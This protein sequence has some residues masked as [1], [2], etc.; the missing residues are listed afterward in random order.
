MN[1]E[2]EKISGW[3]RANKLSINSSKSK[4][5][6][7]YRKQKHAIRVFI[8]TLLICFTSGTY[9]IVHDYITDNRNMICPPIVDDSIKKNFLNRIV[10]CS[11]DGVDCTKYI[12]GFIK[13]IDIVSTILPNSSFNP[14]NGDGYIYGSGGVITI[15]VAR[16]ILTDLKNF[17][18]YISM[19]YYIH[20]TLNGP[21]S[22]NVT[23]YLNGESDPYLYRNST[24]TW[25]VFNKRYTFT[26][27]EINFTLSASGK[28]MRFDDLCIYQVCKFGYIFNKTTGLCEGFN[29]LSTALKISRSG[30]SQSGLM[31]VYRSKD[32]KDSVGFWIAF[33]NM[34]IYVFIQP[35]AFYGENVVLTYRFYSSQR[36]T[37]QCCDSI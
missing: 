32:S 24:S 3:F 6:P 23:Y 20:N 17:D 30:M 34:G 35:L 15:M 10:A 13:S 18:L 22:S 14:S 29:V 37:L 12:I 36:I 1:Q 28:F 19:A 2:L 4:L 31:D 26:E 11:F 27:S 8:Y 16:N 25:N 21:A 5:E 7:L 33:E 9:S